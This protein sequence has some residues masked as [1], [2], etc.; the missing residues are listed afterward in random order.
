MIVKHNDYRDSFVTA[1]SAGVFRP[2]RRQ[3]TSRIDPI[4][5]AKGSR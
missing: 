2:E 4:I 1:G 5:P 3:K